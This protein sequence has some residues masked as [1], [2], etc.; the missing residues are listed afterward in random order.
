MKCA[1]K[2][3][4][5]RI[6]LIWPSPLSG[7]NKVLASNELAQLAL[8]YLMRT[9]QWQIAEQ[10]QIDRETR[11]IITENGAKHPLGSKA[12]INLSRE[13]GG[14]EMKSVE[15]EYKLIQIKAAVSLCQSSDL[16][17]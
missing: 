15:N 7:Y 10:R 4:L 6:S 3:Y 11:K 1:N 12:L 2:V 5:Q 9:Q 14:R 17:M 16:T 13:V 8:R